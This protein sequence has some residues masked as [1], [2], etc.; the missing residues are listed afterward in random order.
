MIEKNR[1][2]ADDAM[3]IEEYE[4]IRK[5]EFFRGVLEIIKKNCKKTMASYHGSLNFDDTGEFSID[6]SAADVS[7]DSRLVRRGA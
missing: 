3:L 7:L 6:E 1:T 4:H 5:R 2:P